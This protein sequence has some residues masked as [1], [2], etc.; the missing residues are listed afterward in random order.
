MGN[1]EE[2]SV[3]TFKDMIAADL[4]NVF[5][6]TEEFAETV[7]YNGDEVT[8]IITYGSGDEYKGYDDFD[9]KAVILVKVSDVQEVVTGDQVQIGSDDWEVIGAKRS[10]HGLTWEI[11]VNKRTS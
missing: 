3:S 8:A 4:G 1:R 11:Q 9:V 5:F 6:N 2:G 7:A 10:A